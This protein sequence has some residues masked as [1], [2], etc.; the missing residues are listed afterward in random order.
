M[1]VYSDVVTGSSLPQ[2]GN[3]VI[4]ECATLD[5]NIYEPL[6]DISLCQDNEE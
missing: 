6:N 1:N 2:T 3:Y 5:D 4:D